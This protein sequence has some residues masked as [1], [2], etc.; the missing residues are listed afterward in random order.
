MAG[1]KGLDD[2]IEHGRDDTLHIPVV[3]VRIALRQSRDQFGFDHP[4]APKGL[5]KAKD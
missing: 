3:Q 4:P 5:G 2:L 1:R